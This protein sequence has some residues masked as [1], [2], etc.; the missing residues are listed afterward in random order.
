[1]LLL[2]TKNILIFAPDYG[3]A[4]TGLEQPAGRARKTIV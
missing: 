2:L 1:M 4:A 3:L